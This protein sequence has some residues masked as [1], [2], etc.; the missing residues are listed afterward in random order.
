MPLTSVPTLGVKCDSSN[1]ALSIASAMK[2]PHPR[3]R[4][5]IAPT[6]AASLAEQKGPIVLALPLPK[7]AKKHPSPGRARSAIVGGF[8][9]SNC[10][11]LDPSELYGAIK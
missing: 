4:P 9:E 2:F 6:M 5:N 10:K 3:L 7:Y 1:N 11:S 8:E